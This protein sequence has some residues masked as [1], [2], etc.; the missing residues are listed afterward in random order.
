MN[1]QVMQIETIVGK[2]FVVYML[3]TRCRPIWQSN[4]THEFYIRLQFRQ[5]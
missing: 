2:H 1:C 3:T 5:R 4:L